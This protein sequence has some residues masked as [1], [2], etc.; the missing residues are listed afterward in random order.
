MPTQNGRKK[1]GSCYYLYSTERERIM[2]KGAINQS[3]AEN[4]NVTAT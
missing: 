2:L 3:I 4:D 1:E